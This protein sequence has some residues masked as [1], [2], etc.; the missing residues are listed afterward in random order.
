[1][2]PIHCAVKIVEAPWMQK[3]YRDAITSSVI[4]GLAATITI[5]LIQRKVPW[6]FLFTYIIFATILKL[7]F[8]KRKE[9]K[10]EEKRQRSE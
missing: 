6:A 10:K 9:A 1:M 8:N 4:T 2:S 5:Y 7:Y 3:V